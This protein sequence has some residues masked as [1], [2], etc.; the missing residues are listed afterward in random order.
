MRVRQ[1]SG[2]HGAVLFSCFLFA[3][4]WAPCAGAGHPPPPWRKPDGK[5]KATMSAESG[6]LRGRVGEDFGD[7]ASPLAP[8][9]ALPSPETQGFW[10]RPTPALAYPGPPCQAST[11]ARPSEASWEHHQAVLSH[12]RLCG[13]KQRATTLGMSSLRIWPALPVSSQ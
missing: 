1:A 11:K 12:V 10:V 13:P 5:S 4:C 8:S 3:A 7:L 2:G 9:P 6:G